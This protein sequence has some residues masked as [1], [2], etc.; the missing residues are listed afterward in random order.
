MDYKLVGYFENWAQYRQAGGK[1][2][3]E[4]IDPSLFTHINF[5]F[6]IFGFVTWSVDPTETRTG[7]QR[8]T[9]DYTLQPVEWNDRK[10]LYPAIQ[11]LKEKNPNLKTLLSI[12]GWSF[13]SCDDT[14]DSAGTLHPFGP[15][16]CQL[17]SKMAADPNG[18]KQFIESSIAYAQDRGFDG[19]DLDWEYPGDRTRGGIDADFDN[20]IAL[21]REFRQA[22]ESSAPGLLLTIAASVVPKG[23]AKSPSEFFKWLAQSVEYLDWVNAMTYDYHGAFDPVT[24]V[25]A[26]LPQDSV[27]NGTFSIKHSIDAYLEAGI[28]KN[29]IV[30]GMPVY[31]RTFIVNE[32]L[33]SSDN[34]YGKPTKQAGPAGKA[35]QTPGFLAY[36]EILEKIASGEFVKVWDEETLTPYAYNS[37]TSE[38]VTF[39]DEK[40]LEAKS[41][42]ACEQGLAGAMVWAIGQDDF[43][44]GF[45][46][47]KQITKSLQSCSTTEQPKTKPQPSSNPLTQVILVF[48]EEGAKFAEEIE[49]FTE[50]ASSDSELAPVLDSLFDSGLFD[51]SIEEIVKESINK[52]E[53]AVGQKIDSNVLN[54]FLDKWREIEEEV[55]KYD[56]DSED[57]NKQLENVKKKIE[58]LRKQVEE[59]LPKLPNVTLP[60]PLAE[61]WEDLANQ[62]SV[63]EWAVDLAKDWGWLFVPFFSLI[64]SLHLNIL[65]ELFVLNNLSNQQEQ[66]KEKEKETCDRQSTEIIDTAEDYLDKLLDLRQKG[67][68]SVEQIYSEIKPQCVVD[69]DTPQVRYCHYYYY[70]PKGTVESGEYTMLPTLFDSQADKMAK[71]RERIRGEL[72]KKRKAD[73]QEVKD[74]TLGVIQELISWLD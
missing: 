44:N 58:E 39:D 21:L 5:A 59:N 61:N 64:A 10:V 32:S 12:G 52:G 46:L 7:E 3:P 8:Y 60:S 56:R 23:E 17:F 29:K 6:G 51:S 50:E 9:G 47:I 65:M 28:P 45:P 55:K 31:G 25:N 57:A 37:K 11:K 38:W 16:T 4:Q 30:L 20:F 74:F 33:T 53:V 69:V 72:F 63:K 27:P 68:L 35:T 48:I 71:E 70:G 15:Y 41:N 13:N 42:Y 24:G 1:F 49:K 43:K 67:S 22:I 62:E 2:L 40:S 26:P 14:P 18:R 73:V 54:E 19:I 36:Y 34:G 66:D